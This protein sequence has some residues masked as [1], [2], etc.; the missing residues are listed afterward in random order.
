MEFQEFCILPSANDVREHSPG[1]M[2]NRMP[3][4]PRTLFGPD[5]TP[6]FIHFGGAIWLDV[7]GHGIDVLKCGEFFLTPRSQSWD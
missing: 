5:E 1:V 2:I 6:H 7:D 3:Q 4:P